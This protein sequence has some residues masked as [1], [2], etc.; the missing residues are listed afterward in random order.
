MGKVQAIITDSLEV[1]D[2]ELRDEFA[3]AN[4]QTVTDYVVL[5]KD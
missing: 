1:S 5:N 2:L 4:L 3:H